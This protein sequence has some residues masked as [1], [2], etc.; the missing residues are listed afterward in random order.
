LQTKRSGMPPGGKSNVT[1]G[2]QERGAG[3]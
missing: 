1:K 3:R 2:F